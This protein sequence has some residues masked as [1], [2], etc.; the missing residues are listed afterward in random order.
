[1]ENTKKITYE[2]REIVGTKYIIWQYADQSPVNEYNGFLVKG[3]YFR[4]YP[5]RRLIASS[6][7]LCRHDIALSKTRRGF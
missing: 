2:V 3:T 6:V 1:M 7:D 4:L 5:S